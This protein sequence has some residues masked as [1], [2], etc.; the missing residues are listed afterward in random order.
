MT[1]KA[2]NNKNEGMKKST[3]VIIITNYQLL[4]TLVYFYIFN[5][6]GGFDCVVPYDITYDGCTSE[7]GK[8]C[9]ELA[10]CC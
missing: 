3:L 6:F 2:S 8:I 5:I 10:F 1:A 7:F 4:K 9:I